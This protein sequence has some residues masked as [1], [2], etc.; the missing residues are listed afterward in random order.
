MIESVSWKRTLLKVE[1]NIHSRNSPDLLVIVKQDKRDQ[2]HDWHQY[3][4]VKD[5]VYVGA[6]KFMVDFKIFYVYRA[7]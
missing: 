7:A 1:E 4:A 3:S 5:V 2:A 6:V